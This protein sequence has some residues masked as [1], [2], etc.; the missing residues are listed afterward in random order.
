MENCP[1]QSPI[2]LCGKHSLNLQDNI[3]NKLCG[4][5]C[6]SIYDAEHKIYIVKDDIFLTSDNCKYRLYEYHFHTPAEHKINGNIYPGEIHYVFFKVGHKHNTSKIIDVCGSSNNTTEED[7]LVIGYGLSDI[8]NTINLNKMKIYIP[9]S[10]FLYDGSLTTPDF[11]P[12]RWIVS[13]KTLKVNIDQ[14]EDVS[15]L[16]RSLQHKNNRIILVHDKM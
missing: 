14:L 5:N 10:Y 6:G 16:A 12:V 2:S 1:Y 8:C 11:G 9:S 13:N 4:H 3:I 7:I 15:K